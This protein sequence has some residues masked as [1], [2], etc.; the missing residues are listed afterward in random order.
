ML[1]IFST[2]FQFSNVVKRLFELSFTKT[3]KV[4]ICSSFSSNFQ[5]IPYFKSMVKYTRNHVPNTLYQSILFE[6]TIKT[7]I[8]SR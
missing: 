5:S 4:F 7:L 8:E 3:W 6:Q 1:S 2:V